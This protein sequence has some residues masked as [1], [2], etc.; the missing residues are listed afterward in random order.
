MRNVIEQHGK[1]VSTEE[2]RILADL[3]VN[4]HACKQEN[5]ILI[6][7]IEA[8]TEDCKKQQDWMEDK[9]KTIE[10]KKKD[11]ESESGKF[12]YEFDEVKQ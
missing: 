7:K 1:L 9:I 4:I 12:F 6:F 2:S 5:E 11:I 10:A 8:E 3:K